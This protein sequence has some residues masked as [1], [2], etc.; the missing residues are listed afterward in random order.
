MAFHFAV[1]YTQ[2]RPARS[3][4]CCGVTHAKSP[5][6]GRRSLVKGLRFGVLVV[7]KVRLR[8]R[9]RRFQLGIRMGSRISLTHSQT[10]PPQAKRISRNQGTT[11]WRQTQ[12]NSTRG[13]EQE[14]GHQGSATRDLHVLFYQEFETIRNILTQNAKHSTKPE[15]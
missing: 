14:S 12:G 11:L 5:A 13:R 7:V 10:S 15:T 8:P 6:S 4:L 9:S 2:P 1:A 3:A